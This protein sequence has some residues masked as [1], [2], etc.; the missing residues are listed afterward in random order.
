MGT[1]SE[2]EIFPIRICFRE[3]DLEIQV[4]ESTSGAVALEHVSG[5]GDVLESFRMKQLLTPMLW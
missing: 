3:V 5:P 1:Y 2:S 4:F